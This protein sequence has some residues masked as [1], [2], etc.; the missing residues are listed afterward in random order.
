[1]VPRHIE[2]CRGYLELLLPLYTS[3]D[4]SSPLFSATSA[5][6]MRTFAHKLG[7]REL[8]Y[9]SKE[10]QLQAVRRIQQAVTNPKASND[11]ATLISIMLLGLFENMTATV[12]SLPTWGKHAEGAAALVKHRGNQMF[13]SNISRRLFWAV[14][15]QLVIN[16]I[17]KCKAMD[18]ALS[19]ST[20]S[21]LYP[22]LLTM[23]NAANRLT[24]LGLQIPA[25]REAGTR[26]LQAQMSTAVAKDVYKLLQEAKEVDRA[27]SGWPLELATS[28]KCKTTRI[29][30][31]NLDEME[32]SDCYPR[33]VHVYYNL[34]VA[35][36]WNTYRGY[37]ILC[38]MIIFNCIERLVPPS[39]RE[40]Y[41][42]YSTT[43]ATLREMVNGICASVPFHLG[44][45]VPLPYSTAE[46]VC[47]MSAE[48]FSRDEANLPRFPSDV[49]SHLRTSKRVGG[50][51]LLWTLFVACS[52][53]CIP[54]VQRTWIMKRFK[55]I[56]TRYG[57][58]Q[59]EVLV[60]LG[61][62]SFER[63]RSCSITDFAPPPFVPLD[64]LDYSKQE[65]YGKAQPQAIVGADKRCQVKW[66]REWL[67]TAP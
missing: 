35:N 3:A 32:A 13:Q 57:I 26:C 15:A 18:P 55:T 1:M 12:E 60:T 43:V 8:D 65:V 24:L 61:I 42:D 29:F 14:L 7:R 9:H 48:D 46:S 63:G 58:S 23:G 4:E 5:V 41:E 67:T 20:V 19:A 2:A 22:E 16:Q 45:E 59:A 10:A 11:D 21:T 33:P 52:V 39:E 17:A 64:A 31:C 49:G 40:D 66:F 62:E 56:S 36:I 44:T 37:R 47:L 51:F 54:K 38:L 50:F 25:L 34:F 6:S 28:W 53:I 27:L 30:A